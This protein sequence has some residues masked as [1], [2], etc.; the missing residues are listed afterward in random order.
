MNVA[1]LAELKGAVQAGQA[2]IT[3]ADESLARKVLIWNTL[4]TIANVAV[5][6]ILAV[7]IFAWADPLGLPMFRAPWAQLARRIVLGVGVL[8]LFAEY[9]LPVV[10]L[11]KPAGSDALGLKLVPRKPK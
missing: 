5:I 1:T 10:R 3:V 4:R 2:E 8:L 6:V 11:Y 7:G 9:A